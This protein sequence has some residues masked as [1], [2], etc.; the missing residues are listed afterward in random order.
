MFDQLY[1][2]TY[3]TEYNVGT[4]FGKDESTSGNK[5]ASAVRQTSGT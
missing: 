1:G 4:Q 2:V 3:G 5:D